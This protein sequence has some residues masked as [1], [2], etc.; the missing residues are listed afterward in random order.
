MI[1]NKSQIN[2]CCCLELGNAALDGAHTKLITVESEEKA[3][4][5]QREH[6]TGFRYNTQPIVF[7][8]KFEC[9]FAF[10]QHNAG[11]PDVCGTA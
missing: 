2:G 4:R 11:E 5:S 1:N 3:I 8:D 9:V 10:H 6:A 7:A